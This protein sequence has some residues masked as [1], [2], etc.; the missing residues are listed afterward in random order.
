M[1]DLLIETVPDVIH[2]LEVVGEGVERVVFDWPARIYKQECD[3]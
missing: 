1:A 2:A 3:Q